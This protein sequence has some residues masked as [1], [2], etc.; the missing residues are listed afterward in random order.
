MQLTI[1]QALQQAVAAHKEG[2]LQEAE[3][4]YRA[5]LRSQPEHPDANHNL[6]VLA[7]TVNKANSALPH[8]EKALKS[9]PNIE[10]FWVSYIDALIKGKQFKIAKK[11]LLQGKKRGIDVKKL[12]TLEEQLLSTAQK[13]TNT[14]VTPPVQQ[15]RTVLEYYQTGQYAAAEELASS[16]TQEFPEHELAW[17]ILA[18]MHRQKG[19]LAEALSASQ[20]VVH[21][22]PQDAEAHNNLG[23]TLKELGR[24]EEAET[25]FR[26]AIALKADYAEAYSNLGVLLREFGRLDEAVANFKKAIKV[27][28]DYAQAHLYLTSMK[29]F[30]KRDK[31]FLKMQK[32][33]KNKGITKEQRCQINF[34][35]AKASEDIGDF[36]QAFMHFSEGNKLRKEILQYDVSQDEERFRQLKVTYPIIERNALEPD[37]VSEGPT[38]VFIVGMPRSGTTLVEQIVSS[39]SQVAG[40]GEL[41]YVAQFGDALARGTSAPNYGSLRRFRENYLQQLKRVGAGKPVITDKMPQ[42]F[43]YIGVIA[44]AFPEAKIVHVIRDPAAVC[45]A[46]YKQYFDSKHLNFSYDLDDVVKY[47]GLYQDLIR[48]WEE[49]LPDRIY[50]LNYELLTTNQ[51]EETRKLIS[52]LGLDWEDNCLSP[53]LNTRN[54][55]TASDLQVRQKV[56][57]GSSLQWK[58]YESFLDGVFDPIKI[59]EGA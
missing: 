24:P 56:Y 20:K 4:Y 57:K 50:D 48:F 5:I 37:S 58:K 54:V 46:N 44:A 39:H 47:F 16:M 11:I 35:L 10:Q 38:P 59:T 9:N 40:S 27:K 21:L 3:R 8:F 17:K 51:E 42:N 22:A 52:Y 49:R 30:T 7:V 32:L 31:Q 55:S 18:E 41:F 23:A 25:C 28:P 45:W 19:L 6:G 36:R 12:D 43:C 33:Y 1:E 34:A 53:E 29:K 15:L 26:Q 2:K 14:S 13:E